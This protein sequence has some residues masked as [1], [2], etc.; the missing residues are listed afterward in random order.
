MLRYL[1]WKGKWWVRQADLRS[2][3]SPCLQEGLVAYSAKQADILHRMGT[4][5][6][7]QWY[8]ILSAYGIEVEWP[9]KFS[10]SGL[11]REATSLPVAALPMESQEDEDGN[12]WVGDDIFGE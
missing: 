5:F 9:E 10:I 11:D 2:G 1:E 7:Q 3:V 12:V 8:P 4:H 6:S